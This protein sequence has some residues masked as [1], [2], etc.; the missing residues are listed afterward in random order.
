MICKLCGGMRYLLCFQPSYE[1]SVDPKTKKWVPDS[2]GREWY[3]CPACGAA[4][5]RSLAG[6]TTIRMHGLKTQRR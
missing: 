6:P 4:G 2:V 3:D 5:V 1:G